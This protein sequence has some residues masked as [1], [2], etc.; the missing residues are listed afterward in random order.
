MLTVNQVTCMVLCAVLPGG[1]CGA[2][3]SGET[4]G[5]HGE[6]T[7]VLEVPVDRAGEATE[8]PVESTPTPSWQNRQTSG[9]LRRDN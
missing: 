9:P 1:L 8:Q 3:S 7:G 4:D 2:V 6:A 5:A